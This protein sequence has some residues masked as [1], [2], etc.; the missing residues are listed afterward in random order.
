LVDRANRDGARLA[1][2]IDQVDDSGCDAFVELQLHGLWRLGHDAA[3]GRFG[4]HQRRMRKRFRCKTE[5]HQQC[6]DGCDG[7]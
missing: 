7:A 3:I 5:R 6:R 2:S 4:S 1:P